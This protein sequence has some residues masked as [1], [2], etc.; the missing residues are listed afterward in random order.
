MLMHDNEVQ[1]KEISTKNKIKE[2]PYIMIKT[3]DLS[4]ENVH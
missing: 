4:R 2:C 3:C 1:L